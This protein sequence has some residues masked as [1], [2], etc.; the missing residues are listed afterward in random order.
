MAEAFG[1]QGRGR[2]TRKWAHS[3]CRES[4]LEIV[5]L[6]T[7]EPSRTILTRATRAERVH[8]MQPIA[9]ESLLADSSAARKEAGV[10]ADSNVET[11]RPFACTSTRIAGGAP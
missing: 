1:V 6:L 9:P 3:D 11:S 5:A 10:A 8:A 7:M 4:L 2:F